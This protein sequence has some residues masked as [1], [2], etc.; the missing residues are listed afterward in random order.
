MRHAEVE[1]REAHPLHVFIVVVGAEIV[2]KPERKERQL[3]PLFPQRRYVIPS[4]GC[5]SAE[6]AIW[7]PPDFAD[8]CDRTMPTVDSYFLL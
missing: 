6:C 8:G 4:L 1:R 2:P 3:Q 5:A 7:I